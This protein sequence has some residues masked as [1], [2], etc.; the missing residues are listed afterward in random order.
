M[1]GLTMLLKNNAL[2]PCSRR[3]FCNNF[4]DKV[5]LNAMIINKNILFV[6]VTVYPVAT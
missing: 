3:C 5:K 6:R 4:V 2:A 1:L